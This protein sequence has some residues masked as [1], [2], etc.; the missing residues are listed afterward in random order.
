MSNDEAAV[1]PTD[2][3][4][5][6]RLSIES[7]RSRA[8][9]GE[10]SL[11]RFSSVQGAGAPRLVFLHANGFNGL[12]YR[13][14]LAPLRE[15]FEILAPDQR[16]QGFTTLPADPAAHFSWLVYRDDLIALLEALRDEPGAPQ[17]PVLL[18]GHS[19]GATVSLLTACKR[20]DLV[21]GL[22]LC[23]PVLLPSAFYAFSSLRRTLKWR[24]HNF[25]IARAALK[26]RRVFESS[27]TMIAAYTG[28]GAFKTW[29][30]EMVADY[31]L[32]GS[33]PCAEGV[34][35]TCDPAWE[36]ANFSGQAHAVWPRLKTLA[37]PLSVLRGEG[38]GSTCPEPMARKLA[39][40]VPT[41]K[42]QQVPGTGH[43]LPMERPERLRAEIL[44]MQDPLELD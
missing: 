22:V 36:A 12:T 29:P 2:P 26:R 40:R 16:G 34:E 21:S 35:L 1:S 17:G 13:L 11:L 4:H 41:A 24:R 23:E 28:R 14:I 7:A 32:G 5:P 6:E 44:A 37:A 8:Q 39:R 3:P 10:H 20:P 15:R 9:G 42:I 43:F 18:A 30:P 38:P 33:R 25:P 19:M 27:D 31:V